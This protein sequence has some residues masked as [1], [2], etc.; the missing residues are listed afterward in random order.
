M[1]A[2]AEI[3]NAML[4][5]KDSDGN[6]PVNVDAIGTSSPLSFSE[7]QQGIGRMQ[8]LIAQSGILV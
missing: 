1:K 3:F 7:S 2:F 8:M 4:G 6:P 5:V